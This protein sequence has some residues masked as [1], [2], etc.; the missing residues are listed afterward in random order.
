MLKL[1]EIVGSTHPSLKKILKM[2]HQ[3][4]NYEY[5][6]FRLKIGRKEI[7][8]TITNNK[9]IFFYS[10]QFKVGLKIVLRIKL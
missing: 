10:K 3:S 7:I 8:E 5:K 6:Y 9:S 1:F 4:C 2:V